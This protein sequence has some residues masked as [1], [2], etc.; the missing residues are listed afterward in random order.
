MSYCLS[1]P[2]STVISDGSEH[3]YL[4]SL[5]LLRGRL[6]LSG[7][8]IE[9]M[10]A[11]ALL[12]RSV[13]AALVVVR[14]DVFGVKNRYFISSAERRPSSALNVSKILSLIL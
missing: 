6:G 8:Y 11:A 4:T 10:R 9:L 14:W 7:V 5:S 2:R 1:S 12:C 13:V 3:A